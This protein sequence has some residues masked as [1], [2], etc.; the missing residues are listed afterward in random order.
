[1]DDRNWTHIF[2]AAISA[3]YFGWLYSKKET[4]PPYVLR[5]GEENILLPSVIGK[6]IGGK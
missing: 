3:F 2:L 5:I 4:S 1:M 6:L